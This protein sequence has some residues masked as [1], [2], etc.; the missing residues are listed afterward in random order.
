MKQNKILRIVDFIT[1]KVRGNLT[2]EVLLSLRT[3]EQVMSEEAVG[4]EWT[5]SY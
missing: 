3:V 4:P 5:G 1:D 2:Y